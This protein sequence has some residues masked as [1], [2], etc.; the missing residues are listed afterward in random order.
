MS[1]TVF[2]VDGV[3]MRYSF[4]ATSSQPTE[5]WYN[6]VNSITEGSD[7]F[8]T[9]VLL[10]NTVQVW[11]LNTISEVWKSIASDYFVEL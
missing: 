11:Q 9:Q 3:A 10:E 2:I 1:A 8:P 5:S 4:D 7:D 6:K